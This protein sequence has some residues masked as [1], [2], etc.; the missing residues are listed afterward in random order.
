[1]SHS[2]TN[3]ERWI[4]EGWRFRIKTSRGHRYITRRRGRQERSLGRYTD[5]LWIQIE[6]LTRPQPTPSPSELERLKANV[7]AITTQLN[8]L[9]T[10]LQASKAQ[11]TATHKPDVIQTM[12]ALQ[13]WKMSR[14]PCAHLNKEGCCTSGVFRTGKRVSSNQREVTLP[15]GQKAYCNYM[16]RNLEECMFCT[17]EKRLTILDVQY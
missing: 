14:F 16:L 2:Q 1:M 7:E 15:N 3:L 11:L 10:D 4:D 6:A 9:T 5:H 17:A 12:R 13:L 8:K